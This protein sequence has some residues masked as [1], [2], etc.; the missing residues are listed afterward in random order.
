MLRGVMFALMLNVGPAFAEAPKPCLALEIPQTDAGYSVVGSYAGQKFEFRV[1]V[2]G[3][4]V[5]LNPKV[6]AKEIPS[7]CKFTS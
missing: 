5:D 6:A 4:P 1:T 3:K 2:D 7:A